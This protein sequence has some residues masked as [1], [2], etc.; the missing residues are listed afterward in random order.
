MK[1][2]ELAADV[3]L[4]LIGRH[5]AITAGVDNADIYAVVAVAMADSLLA[6]LAPKPEPDK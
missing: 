5:D 6:A 4:A 3:L 1:R 2:D